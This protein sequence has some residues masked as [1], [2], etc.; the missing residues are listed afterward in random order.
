MDS[1]HSHPVTLSRSRRLRL[2]AGSGV[3]IVILA[4][5]VLAGLWFAM[6]AARGTF[7]GQLGV[8]AGIPAAGGL[9][10]AGLGGVF[11][12][13][14]I[15]RLS[16]RL[17]ADS[18][19][20]S[21]VIRSTEDAE[22]VAGPWAITLLFV[23]MVGYSDY[24]FFVERAG[25]RLKWWVSASHVV[26][27][28]GGLAMLA[29]VMWRTLQLHKFGKTE[30]RLDRHAV[31]GGVLSGRLFV[32]PAA[33]NAPAVF[34]ALTATRARVW[35]EGR[36]EGRVEQREDTVIASQKRN[37]PVEIDGNRCHVDFEFALASDAPPSSVAAGIILISNTPTEVVY[38][39]LEIRA[40]LPGLDLVRTF[41]IR[42]KPAV[43]TS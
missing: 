19:S 11:L 25:A 3:I 17:G 32:P 1:A 8:S 15:V 31:P 20:E 2:I 13:Q 26:M 30:L 16:R 38:W 39:Q 22:G 14:A 9:W 41:D 35:E 29:W 4:A 34:F 5:V 36:E 40:V 24:Y 43:V 42:V 37:F 18:A 7:A 33:R 27:S 21:L 23:L 10:A 6:T 28:I 12:W